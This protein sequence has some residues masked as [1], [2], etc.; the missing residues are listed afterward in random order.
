LNSNEWIKE[1]LFEF[2]RFRVLCAANEGPMGSKNVNLEIEKE[3][4][5][6]FELPKTGEWYA[7]RPIMVT[8][9][10][11]DL[12]LSNGDVGLVLPEQ[13]GQ[14]TLKAYFLSGD[15]LRI[16]SLSRLVSVQTA[17]AMSIHKSQGSE[18]EHT[19]MI[20]PDR[21]E[22]AL[23]KEML[24]TGVTRAKKYLTL[25]QEDEGLIA[26]AMSQVADRSSGLSAQIK[27]LKKH[28]IK[29]HSPAPT[30]PVL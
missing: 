15:Q 8:R 18:Y 24:Y 6:N 17:F 14:S 22:Q 28:L 11:H 25:V 29:T 7:G 3:V 10:Q 19:L 1:L 4:L 26:K 23:S 27:R 20:L 30:A 13:L 5:R 16:F 12:G 9:N 21:M 2:E